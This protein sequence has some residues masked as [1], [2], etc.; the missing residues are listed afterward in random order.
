MKRALI[1]DDG[2]FMR[3]LIKGM[4]TKNGYE[5]VGEAEDGLIGVEKY[6]QLAPDFVT[7]DITM[8]NMDGLEALKQIISIDSGANVVMISAMG[9]E[10]NIRAAIIN[11]AKGFVVKPFD[12][13]TFLSVIE[14]I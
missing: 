9:Q 14:S 10:A 5:V 8:P 3:L 13:S 4:L 2:A 12:E 1:V 7:M 6:K 11:G